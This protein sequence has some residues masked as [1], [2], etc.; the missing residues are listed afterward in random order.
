[1]PYQIAND[2]NLAILKRR[3]DNV[4]QH[5]DITNYQ[6]RNLFSLYRKIEV[7]VIDVLGNPKTLN[8]YNYEHELCERIDTLAD[9]LIEIGNR[10][11][12]LTDG[13][14]ILEIGGTNY[15]SADSFC[16]GI[17]LSDGTSW[18]GHEVPL[19]N[20]TDVVL[21]NVDSAATRVARGLFTVNGYLLRAFAVNDTVR[22]PHGGPICINS[23][24]ATMGYIDFS[25]IGNIETVD[26]IESMIHKIDDNKKWSHRLTLD[27]GMP[28]ANKSVGI[29]IGGYLHLLDD[30]IKINGDTTFTFSL[31]N[32]PYLNRCIYDYKSLDLS[33]MGLDNISE[34]SKVSDVINPDNIK[35]LLISPYSFIVL[36]D[37]PELM[38]DT[39]AI[40][41]LEYH[42][43]VIYKPVVPGILMDI[44]GKI[45][46]YKITNYKNSYGITHCHAHRNNK[47]LLHKRGFE[48]DSLINDASHGKSRDSRLRMFNFS[49]RI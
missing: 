11:L 36:V 6:L 1:M 45:V 30:L 25:A 20:I 21:D 46:D 38:K 17:S 40:N 14:P 33:F 5:E 13:F 32:L 16:S 31:G 44:D 34:S 18:P 8:L 23:D 49:A 28:I 3:Q 10:A 42:N 26:I 43:S 27:V 37:N 19:E 9:W 35:Q 29:V 47:F 2:S 41:N 12:I 22:I 7:P 4:W 39:I 48:E 15:V 24:E